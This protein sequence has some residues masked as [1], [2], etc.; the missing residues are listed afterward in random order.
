MGGVVRCL[1]FENLHFRSQKVKNLTFEKILC[2]KY[3]LFTLVMF[4]PV[5][6][7]PALVNVLARACSVYN[8][9]LLCFLQLQ[10]LVQLIMP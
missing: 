6:T 3:T 5:H 8:T 9:V 2:C 1:T 10:P 7:S 4:C